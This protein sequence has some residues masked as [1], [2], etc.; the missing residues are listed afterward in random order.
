MR[1]LL[2]IAY[3]VGIAVDLFPGIVSVTVVEKGLGIPGSSFVGTLLITL[4]QGTIL[5]CLVLIF[6][7]VTYGIQRLIFTMPPPEPEIACT[8]CGYDLRGS[9]TSA[10]CPE[11]G[12]D[13]QSITAAAA[14]A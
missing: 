9:L 6:M 14:S 2:S 10:T 4:I 11:C 1:L 12:S 8:K 3:P 13:I 5:N 7:L